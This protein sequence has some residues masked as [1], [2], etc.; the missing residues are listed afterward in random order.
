VRPNSTFYS[1]IHADGFWLTLGMY[2]TSEFAA[3]AYD[4]AA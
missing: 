2:N 3:R 1:E 4:V